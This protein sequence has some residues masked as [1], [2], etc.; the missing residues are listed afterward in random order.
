MDVEERYRGGNKYK[1][2]KYGLRIYR[3]NGKLKDSRGNYY[4]GWNENFD[5]EVNVHDPRIRKPNQHAKI[6]ENYGI[7]TTY[8]LDSKNFNDLETFL[9]VKLF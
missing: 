5:K 6:I 3:Q 2:I 7:I 1:F 4:Y 9:P 8:P